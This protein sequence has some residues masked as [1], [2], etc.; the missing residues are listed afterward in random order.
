[1]PGF[2]Y[3]LNVLFIRLLNISVQ[4]KGVCLGG[5]GE[6]QVVDANMGWQ[7]GGEP[8]HFGH[9]LRSQGLVPFVY[10][11]GGCLIAFK[12]YQRKF[13]FC[14]TGVNAGNLYFMA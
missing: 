13:G 10:F 8:G 7:G 4:V 11:I 1:M 2:S 5:T 9:I 3:G 14:G 6:Y 12:A